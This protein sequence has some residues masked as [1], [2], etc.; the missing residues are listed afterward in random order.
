MST[1]TRATVF[2]QECPTCGRRLRIRVDYLGK[3]IQCRH[4]NAD[5]I[6][7][8]VDSCLPSVGDKSLMDRVAHLLKLDSTTAKDRA[9]GA[10]V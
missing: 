1:A 5:F 7:R 4:C 8:D 2:V 10:G 3:V 6:A 9:V